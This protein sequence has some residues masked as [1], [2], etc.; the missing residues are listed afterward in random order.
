MDCHRQL[1]GCWAHLDWHCRHAGLLRIFAG[2]DT[3][4]DPYCHAIPFVVRRRYWCWWWRGGK[5]GL[6]ELEGVAKRAGED[7]AL[8]LCQARAISQTCHAQGWG[9]LSTRRS[10]ARRGTQ[11]VGRRVWRPPTGEKQDLDKSTHTRI[12]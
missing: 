7:K 8:S 11:E 3:F 2:T 6:L 5:R 4:G 12:Y 1:T 10:G 9:I